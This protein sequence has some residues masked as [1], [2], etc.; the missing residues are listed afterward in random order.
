MGLPNAHI[1]FPHV[2]GYLSAGVVVDGPGHVGERVA[3]RGA[4]HQSHIVVPPSQVHSIAADVDEVDAALWQLG[5]TCLNG[6]RAGGHPASTPLVVV[7]A[8]LVGAITRRLAVARGAK[9]CHV[10]AASDAKAWSIRGEE[11]V[12]FDVVGRRDQPRCSLVV[13][14]SGSP[15]G[16]PVALDHV[17]DGGTVVLLGSPRA[18]TAPVDMGQLQDRGLRIIGAHID[19]LKFD[20]LQAAR[21][22]E[23]L[24]AEYHNMLEHGEVTFRNLVEVHRAETAPLVYR[25]ISTDAA[26]VAVAFDWSAAPPKPRRK[27]AQSAA[28][29]TSRRRLGLALLGCGDVGERDAAMISASDRCEL[30]SV[31]DPATDLASDIA[32]RYRT[33]VSASLDEI[34]RRDDIGAVVIATPHDTHEGLG[35]AAMQ[36]GKH[37]LFEKPLGVDVGAAT[38]IANAA[39]SVGVTVGVWLPLRYEPSFLAARETIAD[40]L[41]GR[42]LGALSTYLIDK[43]PA[44]YYG[45]YSGREVSTWRFDRTRSGGGFVLMNLYHHVDAIVALVGGPCEW[46]E[47]SMTPSAIAADIEESA[48]VCASFNGLVATFVG[49][50]AVVGGPGEGLAVWGSGGRVELLPKGRTTSLVSPTTRRVRAARLDPKVAALDAFLESCADGSRPE[51]SVRDALVV[52]AV[53]NAAYVAAREHRRVELDPNPA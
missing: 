6:L 29:R 8:G 20:R 30:V 53:I 43:S 46:V 39:D 7:G 38:R 1:G 27:S 42:P 25:R 22:E 2:P 41:L 31:F 33:S 17:A 47:A 28:T 26:L 9:A 35:V 34:L 44:Y 12:T 16:L 13:D 15:R 36:A 18:H 11:R 23:A 50:A 10:L 45:G 3:I 37:V 19:T 4:P 21:I 52:H 5:I 48:T 51:A 24:S 14:A 32:L 49:S 40:G